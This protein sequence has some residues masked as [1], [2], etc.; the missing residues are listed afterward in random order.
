MSPRGIRVPLLTR[1]G[2]FGSIVRRLPP[3]CL[4]QYDS[5]LTRR[6]GKVRLSTEGIDWLCGRYF[7]GSPIVTRSAPT[8]SISHS[9]LSPAT[10]AATPEGVP[11][12]MMSPAASSTI[13]ESFEMIS[14]TFQII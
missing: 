5:A 6:A 11:V 1:R 4:V 3:L 9:I 2:L 10:V 7:S 14:G 13:S 8:P 12:M